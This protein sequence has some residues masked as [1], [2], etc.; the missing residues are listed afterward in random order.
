MAAA[1]LSGFAIAVGYFETV[2]VP[3]V[4][5]EPYIVVEA[6]HVEIAVSAV[7]FV[8]REHGATAAAAAAVA[9]AVVV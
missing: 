9:V 2:V 1:A 8:E 7:E 6:E 4:V 5:V 3:V